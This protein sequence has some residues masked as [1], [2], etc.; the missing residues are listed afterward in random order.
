MDNLTNPGALSLAAELACGLFLG[1]SLLGTEA[2][3]MGETSKF[4]MVI[5]V[6]NYLKMGKGKVAAQCSCA[7]VS[8]YMQLLKRNPELL[9]QWEY[10]GQ[11]KVVVTALDED[12]FV[13]LLSHAKQLGLTDTG[14][15]QIAPGSHTVLGVGPGPA[16]LI[17]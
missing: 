14:C 11:P 6:S 12:S 2:S 4:K 10:C 9:K 13:E 5:V 1:C 17:E 3:I 8:A 7:A 15:T 16:N